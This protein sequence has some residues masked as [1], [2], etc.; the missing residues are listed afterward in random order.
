MGADTYTW[1]KGYMERISRQDVWRIAFAIK[2]Q[3]V[4]RF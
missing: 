1:V 3:L 4:L 2:L